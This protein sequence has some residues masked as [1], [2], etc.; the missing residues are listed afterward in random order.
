MWGPNALAF[1]MITTRANYYVVGCY[2]PPHDLGM[3]E[4]V[5]AV[6]AECPKSFIPMLIGDINIGLDSSR[7]DREEIIA[8]QCNAWDITNMA[9]Q[10]WQ[11][12][13]R[14][15]AGR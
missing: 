4:K 2:I 3:L 5:K 15:A 8:E 6:C 1:R 7:N 13:H 12:R 10:F 11:R 14:N 9:V